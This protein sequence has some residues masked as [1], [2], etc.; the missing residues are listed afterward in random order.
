MFSKMVMV[1]VGVVTHTSTKLSW[2]FGAECSVD[3]EDDDN[4][5][6]VLGMVL[7]MILLLLVI[8]VVLLLL[9]K[10]EGLLVVMI[11]PFEPP[12]PLAVV[13]VVAVS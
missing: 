7:A 12:T 4:D 9:L 1:A 11:D 10:N 6:G 3:D 5:V 8:V 2:L 13:A